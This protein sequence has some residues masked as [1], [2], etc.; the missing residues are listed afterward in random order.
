MLHDV[1]FKQ[2]HY[3]LINIEVNKDFFLANY[4]PNPYQTFT[5]S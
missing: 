4:M 2:K 1:V 3:V 5:F